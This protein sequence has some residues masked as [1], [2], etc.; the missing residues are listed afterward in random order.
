M[1]RPRYRLTLA[2]VA[3]ALAGRGFAQQ[4][5]VGTVTKFTGRPATENELKGGELFLATLETQVAQECIKYDDLNYMDRSSVDQVFQELKLSSDAAF[6]PTSGA[7]RGLLGRLDYLIVIDGSSPTIARMRAIDNQTGAVRSI[8]MCRQTKASATASDGDETCV[9]GFVTR[10]HPF[11]AK[12]YAARVGMAEAAANAAADAAQAQAQT[13]AM[14]PEMDAA[15]QRLAAAN[16]FWGP[17]RAHVSSGK[18]RPEIETAFNLANADG[19]SCQSA[20]QTYQ[21]DSLAGCVKDLNHQL[22][23]LQSYR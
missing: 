14:K 13:I 1:K 20:Y 4:I 23:L 15:L 16:S 17:I 21:P 2:L 3:C 5:N 18:L 8:A 19:K 22:D 11:V 12:A 6:D 7:L 9:R 10:L